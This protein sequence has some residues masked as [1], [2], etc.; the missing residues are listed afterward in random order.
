[1]IQTLEIDIGS[2]CKDEIS[3]DLLKD[4]IYQAEKLGVKKIILFK[5]RNRIYPEYDKLVSLIHGLNIKLETFNV[6]IKP[7]NTKKTCFVNCFKHISSCFVSLDGNVFPC[8]GLPL[9]IGNIASDDLVGIISNSEIIQN[10][11]NYRSMIKGP[12]RKCNK[13]LDCYGCR[14]RAYTL[15]GDYLSSDPLC[16]ENK[17][18]HD[19]I[20]YLPMPVDN[21]IPQ[22]HGMRVV[23]TLLKVEERF[24]EVESIISQD[25]PFAEKDGTLNN[26]IYMEI[27]AQSAAVMDGFS[28]F[29]T[30]ASSPG[31]FLIGGKNIIINRKAY[32][33]EKLITDIYKTAKFGSFGV[34]TAAIRSK[35]KTVARGEIKIFQNSGG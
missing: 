18:K 11:K 27:M 31:G 12:C 28:K 1:M 2:K 16:P 25:S 33:N 20:T 34:L 13:F 19:Q 5:D 23:S 17:N 3:L 21:L 35:D 26:V 24:A 4:L 9:S 7:F 8:K 10:L 22:K 6:L 30:G 14:A 15:T 32:V 29:D